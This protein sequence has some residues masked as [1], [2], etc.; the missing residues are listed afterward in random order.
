MKKYALLVSAILLYG[1]AAAAADL[2]LRSLDTDTRSATPNSNSIMFRRNADQYRQLTPDEKAEIERQREIARKQAE[3]YRRQQEEYMRRKAELEAQRRA[4]E[5]AERQR[6]EA[7]KPITLYGGKLKIYALVNGE[8]I[9]SS[10]M[11]SRINA[12]IVA[13][14]IPYNEKTKNMIVN[15][16]LQAAIDEK[17]KIQE[18]KKN[19]IQVSQKEIDTAVARFEKANN[20]PRGQLRNLLAESKVSM[21]VWTTQ[22]EAELA[23]QKLMRKKALS[24]AHVSESEISQ[25]I[26]DV[27]KDMTVKKYMLS[28][29]V[30]NKK[31]AKDIYQLAEV[32]QQDPR[33]SLYAMQFS[34]SPSAANGGSLGWVAK[35]RLPAPLENVFSKLKEGQVSKPVA[36]GNDYYIFKLEKIFHPDTDKNAELSRD[37]VRQFLQNKKL[38]DYSIKAIKD[39]RNRALIEK[40]L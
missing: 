22:I 36:Y 19:G 30:I 12:F 39:L 32:L 9:T 11:Q 5:E 2:N 6:R 37:G 28:E 31:D 17:L 33:F 38:E 7:L 34:Q 4:E 13:T 29:I 25:A 20:I 23:W 1:S 8:V 35:G 24:Y 40:K 18:A 26:D 27:R 21:S 15:K 16:V 10:E 14:G 3:E